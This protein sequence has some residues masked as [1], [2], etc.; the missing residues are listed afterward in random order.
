MSNKWMACFIIVLGAACSGDETTGDP[1][2]DDRPLAYEG[3]AYRSNFAELSDGLR[4]HYLDEG[5]GRPILLIH[6]VPT[7]AYLWRHVIPALEPHGR[8]IAVDLVNFGQSDKTDAL[9]PLQHA[10]RIEQFVEALG[11]ED[12]T[13]VLQDWGGPIGFR[14]ASRHPNNVRALVFFETPPFA[15]DDMSFVPPP[16][17]MNVLHPV[18]G[19][20]GVIDDNFFVECFVLTNGCGGTALHTWTDDERAVYRAPFADPATREQLW[21][22]PQY[23]PFLDATGHP[24]LDPDG[25]GGEPAQAVPDI[26]MFASNEQYLTTTDVPKLFLYGNGSPSVLGQ[27]LLSRIEST[28]PNVQT[29]AVG[30]MVSPPAHFIQED[31]PEDLGEKIAAFLG[32]L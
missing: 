8:V 6:G 10:E 17:R 25:P 14:Y 2:T 23:L 19:R 32:G 9:S 11:L 20:K 1:V 21:L 15:F 30:S 13:L 4:M 24:V 3:L 16:F 31:A 7:Q 12:L 22:L 27:P 18:S 29:V 26:D 28:M 5:E